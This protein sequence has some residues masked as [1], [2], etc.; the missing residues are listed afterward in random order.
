[1][2]STASSGAASSSCDRDYVPYLERSLEAQPDFPGYDH[3]RSLWRG[4]TGIRLV[5]QRLAPSEENLDRLAELIAANAQDERCEVMWG[6]PGTILARAGELGREAWRR[7]SR[8]A[9]A[10]RDPDGVWTQTQRT[11]QEHLGP[12]HGFAGCMLALAGR[13]ESSTSR[14]R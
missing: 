12:A 3:E 7:A 8:G 2:R 10:R 11:D 4:E 9:A 1:M 14:R 5:L 13:G 6:S